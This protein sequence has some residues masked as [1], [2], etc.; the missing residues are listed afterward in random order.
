MVLVDATHENTVLWI[1]DK[2]VRLRELASS[3][4][5]PE[6]QTMRSSPPKPPT[7]DDLKQFEESR[8]I[9][10]PPKIE[11]PFD[12]LPARVQALQLWAAGNPKLSAETDNFFAEELQLLFA[13]RR[14][15]PHPLGD[16]PLVVV[17]A[18]RGHDDGPP[19]GVSADEW[20]AILT[21]KRKQKA[22]L[23]TL[24]TAGELVVAE[25]SG[26]H[27]HLENPKLVVDSIR[28]VVEAAHRRMQANRR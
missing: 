13:E 25:T 5:I 17:A 26:H 6:I 3:R 27:V 21:E 2:V 19:P 20:S 11:P 1:K 15:T 16:M 4:P 23:A 12:R 22:D 9:F 24:S 10:G 14:T 28:R 7:P 8:R 18:G